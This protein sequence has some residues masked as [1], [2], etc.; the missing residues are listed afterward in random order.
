MAGTLLVNDRTAAGGNVGLAFMLPLPQTVKA[1]K[2]PVIECTFLPLAAGKTSL[3]LGNQV[4]FSKLADTHADELP[5][6]FV[7]G[8]VLVQ[9]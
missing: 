2:Q 5:V 4:V 9:P 1:G 8:T 6:H 3:T 7:N